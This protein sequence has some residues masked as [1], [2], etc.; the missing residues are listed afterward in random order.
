VVH[1]T[2]IDSLDRPGLQPYLTLRQQ[3]DHYRDRL[4]VAEGKKVIGRLLDSDLTVVSM[5]LLPELFAEVRPRL[6]ER[7]ES[8]EVFL[9]D[10]AMLDSLTGYTL[11]QGWLACARIPPPIELEVA[12]ATAKRPRFLVALDGLNNAENLGGVVRN[13]AAFGAQ[14][15]VVGETCSHPYLR[16]SVRTS[17]GSLFWLPVIEP[18]SLVEALRELRRRGF[19]C[20]AAHPHTDQRRLPEAALEGDC[21]IVLGNEGDGLSAAVREACDECVAVPMQAGVDSLNVG[22][23]AAVFFYEVWR[24]RHGN[25]RGPAGTTPYSTR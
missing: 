3:A 17:M 22:A 7:A 18:V 25:A 20:V 10:A 23:A 14:G 8:I 16:R 24:Q 15:L 13:A 9:G 5:L 2:K 1:V 21:C 4:F 19:R 12:L 11:Y 6:E